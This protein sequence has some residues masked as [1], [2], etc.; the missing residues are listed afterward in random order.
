M[1]HRTSLRALPLV[2]LFAGA[3]GT[4]TL[5]ETPN[6][7]QVDAQSDADAPPD[8][9]SCV[10][11]GAC[12]LLPKSCCGSCGAA[13]PTDMIGVASSRASAYRAFVCGDSACPACF[14]EQ[15]PFLQSFCRDGAC[16]PIDLHSDAMTSCTADADC[17]LRYPSC[18]EP[19]GGPTSG[20]LSLNKDRIVDYRAE[21]CAPDT[22]CP[23]CAVIYPTDR[24]AACDA[25][26]HC[27]VV[28][29][30]AP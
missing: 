19:C 17:A 15:D 12:M 9:L 30:S 22:V 1:P 21:I 25:T 8:F 16:A 23:K 5:D 20:L 28:A 11:P 10:G 29:T 7:A 4:R 3:C 18:C 27:S 13:T 14:M 24:R 6:D 26:G 2:L